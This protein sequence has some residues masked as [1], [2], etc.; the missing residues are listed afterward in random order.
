MSKILVIEDEL[1]FQAFLFDI[2]EAHGFQ[3]VLANNGNLGL[4]MAKEQLPDLILSDIKMP[5][6]N[7]YEVLKALRQ[8]PV[9]ATI[10]FIFLTGE[11]N[12]LRYQQLK[13]LGAN[14]LLTKPVDNSVL[15][16]VI[17]AQLAH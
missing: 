6:L 17:N 7:G 11:E 1:L 10:P 16:R 14:G 12:R 13:E 15:I 3:V 2:L 5:E 4:Q 9:T 8:D